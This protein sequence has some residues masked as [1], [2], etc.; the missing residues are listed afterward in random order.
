ML[1]YNIPTDTWTKS[2]ATLS[3]PRSD[4]CMAA[5]GGVLYAA[6]GS[7]LLRSS[8]KLTTVGPP[9]WP[10]SQPLL[11]HKL[12]SSSLAEWPALL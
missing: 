7:Q 11:L 1:I 2:T 5:V 4:L 3:S 8:S 6:G 9:G 12:C 10:E